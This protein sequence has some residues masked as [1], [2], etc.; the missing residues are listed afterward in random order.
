MISPHKME[1]EELPEEYD[2]YPYE[3]DPDETYDQKHTI[4]DKDSTFSWRKPGQA[5]KSEPHSIN[6]NSRWHQPALASKPH[7][8]ILFTAIIFH[9]LAL[10]TTVHALQTGKFNEANPIM[11]QTIKNGLATTLIA[12]FTAYA[13]ITAIYKKTGKK[14][15]PNI[16]LTLFATD[17]VWDLLAIKVA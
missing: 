5:K 14:I 17:L 2:P 10:T 15:I 3:E 12:C 6:P 7:W 11:A 9:L 16:A 8:Q 4:L 13:T 1:T